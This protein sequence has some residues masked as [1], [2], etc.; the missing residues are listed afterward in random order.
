MVVRQQSF[1]NFLK[2]IRLINGQ[3][4]ASNGLK[5]YE[6]ISLLEDSKIVFHLRVLN[7]CVLTDHGFPVNSN[8]CPL[9]R[10]SPILSMT[11][12]VLYT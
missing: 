3:F 2:Q 12:Y 11:V 6:L 10:V 4:L 9:L 7:L 5:K 8:N 1:D